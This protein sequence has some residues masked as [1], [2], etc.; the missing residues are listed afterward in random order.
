MKAP[1]RGQAVD[2]CA[3]RVLA[4]AEVDVPSRMAPTGRVGPFA[5]F[6]RQQRRVEVALPF[7]LGMGRWVEVGRA[8]DECRELRGDRVHHFA[9]GDA[10]RHPLRIGR[11]D[12]NVRIP[13]PWQLCSE[14]RTKFPR[15]IGKSV[16]V[17]IHPA[18]P[19][20]LGLCA[21]RERL[22]KPGQGGL[23]QQ[24]GR[25][26]WPAESFL[27]LLYVGDTERRA[28][29]LE[30]VLLGRAEAEMRAD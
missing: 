10:R 24:E 2:D 11:E 13:T 28:V 30:A 23:W 26:A 4:N 8:A 12:R 25:L 5:V 9:A 29:C 16:R 20:R 14:T 27:G 18:V 22:A 19:F 6:A 15:Q 3:H 21:A 17:G 1:V 7:Q